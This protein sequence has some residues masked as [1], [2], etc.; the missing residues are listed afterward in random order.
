MQF[1]NSLKFANE[2]DESDPLKKFR[3]RFYIP[4]IN[5][6]ESIYFTGNSL[7]LQPKAA[8][9]KVLN[10]MED[11]ANYGVEGHFTGKQPWSTYHDQ[12]PPKLTKLT[13]AKPEE[14]VVMNFLT[15]NLHLMFGTFY[16]PDKQRY[17][18]LCEKKAFP[19]DQYAFY[20]QAKLHGLNPDDVIIEVS[21]RVGE[22]HLRTEDILTCIKL[23]AD[24]LCIIMFSGVN[25]YT[26]QFFEIKEI[27]NAAHQVGAKC[28]F[29][30]A[31]AIGNVELELHEWNVDFAVWCNYKYLNAGPGAV[32]GAFIHEKFIRNFNL[33]R[34]AGWWG[35]DKASRFQMGEKFI[36]IDSAEGWQLSTP[37]AILMALLATSLEI[38]EEAGFEN[39]IEKSKKQILYLLYLLDNLNCT[40]PEARVTVI[41]PNESRGNQSSILFKTDG[42][43]IFDALKSKGVLCDWREPNVIRVSPVPLYNTFTEIFE[44]VEIIKKV[45]NE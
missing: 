28:G 29:D 2:L 10:I 9:D 39:I 43:K 45:V 31:H 36:P 35:H 14:L 3:S 32:G 25:Y 12:L 24:S 15:V 19:S 11:W 8:Q 17:K 23:H 40:L 34:M 27:T 16:K 20:S 7:G 33:D 22:Y 30:L 44:F 13:G 6:K 42:K 18:I 21:P 1:E 38:F 4:I 26:G 37:P 5:G 41:T